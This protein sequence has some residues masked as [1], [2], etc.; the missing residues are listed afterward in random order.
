MLRWKRRWDWDFYP[1]RIEK[2]ALPPSDPGY[3]DYGQKERVLW[4][5][6]GNTDRWHET[7]LQDSH[8]TACNSAA[9]NICL[10]TA[11]SFL[12]ARVLLLFVYIRC[13]F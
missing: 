4:I 6:T 12:I 8:C 1:F 5:V 11:N 10:L 3:R 13:L 2:S 7:A 9:V